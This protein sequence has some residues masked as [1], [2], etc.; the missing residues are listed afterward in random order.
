M[1][2]VKTF[3]YRY[4]V[5][6]FNLLLAAIILG[7]DPKWLAILPERTDIDYYLGVFILL[8][9]F[10]EFA[11]I[12]FKSRVNFSRETSLHRVT[13]SYIGF[14]FVPR[15][16]VTGAILTL[17]LDSMGALELSDFFLL[18]IVVVATFKEFFVG[19]F[20]LDSERERLPVPKGFRRKIG[21]GL[22]FLSIVIAYV[23]IWKVYLLEHKHIMF[24]ILSPINWGFAAPAFLLLLFCLEMPL[25][26][27]EFSLNKPRSKR[28]ISIVT[29]LFPV[30]AL[31][32][33]FF[34]IGYFG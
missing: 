16:L 26:Y 1:D 17:A 8:G 29:L 11:G 25:F 15:V 21:D 6:V 28:L 4:K 3:A 12:W 7:F 33:R 10:L 19:S 31:L 5:L 34:L 32:G 18:P 20:Y 2:Q 23:S 27:E 9:L 30:M 24:A 14:T 22:L 13:P